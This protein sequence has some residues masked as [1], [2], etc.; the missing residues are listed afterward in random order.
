MIKDGK[1]DSIV[2]DSSAARNGVLIH[3]YIVEING[4]NVLGLKDKEISELLQTSPPAVKLTLM[5]EFFYNHL[6]KK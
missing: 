2:K 3:H 5:P 1:V 4:V 6:T